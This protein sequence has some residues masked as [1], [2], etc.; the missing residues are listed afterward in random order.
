MKTR[1]KNGSQYIYKVL[2][3]T[4]KI[5]K[6]ERAST[7]EM[8]CVCVECSSFP[9]IKQYT[10]FGCAVEFFFLALFVS[11]WFYVYTSPLFSVLSFEFHSAVCVNGKNE[12]KFICVN[13]Q[14]GL[15]SLSLCI[16][17]SSFSSFFEIK[18]Y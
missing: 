13:F 17:R 6:P 3:N 1:N 2:T 12:E 4:Y 18:K 14:I 16:L 7:H 8:V 9:S 15:F 11:S 10:R 5:T